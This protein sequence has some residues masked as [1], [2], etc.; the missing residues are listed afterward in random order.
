ML[1][2]VNIQEVMKFYN[3]EDKSFETDVRISD[4]RSVITQTKRTNRITYEPGEN[5]SKSLVAV[6]IS[7]MSYS[8]EATA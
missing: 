2:A 7:F 8:S 4:C 3:L 1:S 5:K 6:L